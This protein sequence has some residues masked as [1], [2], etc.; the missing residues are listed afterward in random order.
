MTAYCHFEKPA[1]KSP[2][3]PQITHIHTNKEWTEKLLYRARLPLLSSL[4]SCVVIIPHRH[5]QNRHNILARPSLQAGAC[6][7]D[8]HLISYFADGLAVKLLSLNLSSDH[9]PSIGGSPNSKIKK[10]FYMCTIYSLL[11]TRRSSMC[12]RF[13][14]KMVSVVY[15]MFSHVYKMFSYMYKMFSHIYS[16]CSPMY[17][18]CSTL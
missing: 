10:V 14:D 15:K 12:T 9:N 7:N 3:Q 13:S 4:F 1:R 18:K 2:F 6:K 5:T 11:C 16:R 8:P 17:T